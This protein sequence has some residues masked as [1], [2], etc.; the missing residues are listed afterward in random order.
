MRTLTGLILIGLMTASG[1]A[2]QVAPYGAD[3]HRYQ[4]QRHQ[5]R[6]DSLRLQ[7]DA[8]A[9]TARRLQGETRVTLREL[10]D[11]RQP[12]IPYVEQAAP[13]SDPAVTSERHRQTRE[14]VTQIDDWLER[15]PD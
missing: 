1:A 10:E 2:A 7:A 11:R 5:A 12:P 9:E 14:A 15:T 13:P 3:P 4:V 6:M 8:R